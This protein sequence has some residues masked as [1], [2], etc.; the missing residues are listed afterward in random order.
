MNFTVTITLMRKESDEGSGVRHRTARSARR[1]RPQQPSDAI[2]RHVVCT[3]CRRWFEA[4]SAN[5][6]ARL[7]SWSGSNHRCVRL[8][9]GFQRLCPRPL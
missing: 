1:L 2:K 3:W 4:A 8:P 6:P 5:L 7:S 9:R